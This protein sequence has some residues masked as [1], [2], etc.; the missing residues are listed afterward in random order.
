MLLFN[1]QF[2]IK[3]FPLITKW[4]MWIRHFCCAVNWSFIGSEDYP[5]IFNGNFVLVEAPGTYSLLVLFLAFGRES[6]R[7]FNCFFKIFLEV[8]NS[9]LP[10]SNKPQ[11]TTLPGILGLS[12][13]KILNFPS[14][15]L[16]KN[17]FKNPHHNSW[18]FH[19]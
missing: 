12:L 3:N 7:N 8:E 6:S 2:I 1:F 13:S 19:P 14:H 17:S 11:K 9:S 10:I 18:K 16:K 5:W 4:I 15:Q